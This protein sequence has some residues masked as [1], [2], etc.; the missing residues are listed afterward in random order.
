[1]KKKQ[2]PLMT[3]CEKL[4]VSTARQACDRLRAIKL[5]SEILQESGELV[6][7]AQ[8]EKATQMLWE[9]VGNDLRY[10][11]PGEVADRMPDAG[12]ANAAR[13]AT[14]AAV[15]VIIQSWKKAGVEMQDAQRK[16]TSA[17]A[18][19]RKRTRKPTD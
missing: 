19:I 14:A 11:L 6:W 3:V 10:T 1:M 5:A 18:V 15:E 17:A 12:T 9:M 16:G 7:R 2:N 8:V 4:T 13:R